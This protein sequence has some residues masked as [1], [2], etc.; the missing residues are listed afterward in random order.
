MRQTTLII[1]F[2]ICYVFCF[3]QQPEQD[4]IGAIPLCSNSYHQ[5]NSYSGTGNVSAEINPFTSCLTAGERNDS[6]YTFTV[7]Q[8][9]NVNFSITPNNTADDYDWAVFNITNAG[10]SQ[11]NVDAS[12]EV[13]CNFSGN[14]GCNGVTGPNGN[15]QGF[16]GL[17][18]QP[19]IPVVAGETYVINVSNFSATQGG[20]TIDFS[21]STAIIYDTIPPVGMNSSMGCTKNSFS[22]QMNE[23]VDCSTFTN[24]SGNDF[25]LV[26]NTGNHY[27]ISS[28]IGGNCGFMRGSAAMNFQ[29]VNP[30]HAATTLYLLAATG[31]DGNTI[32]DLCGNFVRV[33]DTIAQIEVFNDA[34]LNIGSD[35]QVCPNDQL[36]ILNAPVAAANYVWMMNGNT[37][38]T[39]SPNF[40]PLTQ[41]DYSL[42]VNYGL[43]CTASD[44]LTI[45]FLPAPHVYLGRD[46]TICFNEPK[47][48]LFAANAGSQFSWTLNGIP[49]GANAPTLQTTTSGMYAVTVKSTCTASDSMLLKILDPLSINLP[50]SEIICPNDSVLLDGSFAGAIKYDWIYKGNFYAS[51][52]MVYI[53]NSGTYTLLV[54]D[55]NKCTG[56][57]T[58]KITQVIKP[59]APE[60]QC[61]VNKGIANEFRWSEIAEASGYEVSVDNGITWQYPSSGINGLVHE[62][63]L[64]K[65][66][67]LVRALSQGNCETSTAMRSKRCNSYI[68]N[69]LTP[70]SDGKNDF[71]TITNIESFPMTSVVILNR[72][73]KE[74]FKTNDYHNEWGGD[75]VMSGSFF[76]IV[77]FA[78]RRVEK[79]TLTVIR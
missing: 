29:L 50:T 41:G 16:C 35:I 66:E 24:N 23:K 10:C 69:I 37:A 2:C 38:G 36:P 48:V 54:V 42:T 62:T 21:S 17:Q 45:T 55:S 33:G 6:W 14:T 51:T 56:S 57:D 28:V 67:I 47:P 27:P 63:S 7:S 78:D 1:L 34:T 64:D 22:L 13:S 68:S 58:I 11:I 60:V 75:S 31:T 49:V 43:G 18:N 73:G 40:Q 30:V 72:Y 53:S 74:V 19:I 79:G 20:Y 39:N 70:N 12:L 76:Y 32:S 65:I 26:D 46:T 9:G 5:Q 59:S 77:S 71:F 4:C 8:S 25:L 15:M 3:G 61:P 52:P 44:S